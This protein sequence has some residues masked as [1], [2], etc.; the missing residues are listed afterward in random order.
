[1]IDYSQVAAFSKVIMDQA[2]LVSW[3][4]PAPAQEAHNA[5]AKK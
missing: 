3:P 4:D 5:I 2:G 1:L